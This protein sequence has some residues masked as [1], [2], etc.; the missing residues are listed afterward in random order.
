MAALRP[1]GR[2]GAQ[3]GVVAKQ[4]VQPGKHRRQPAA[5]AAGIA[6]RCTRTTC[7]RAAI[8]RGTGITGSRPYVVVPGR[9]EAAFPRCCREALHGL[10]HHHVAGRGDRP[11]RDGRQGKQEECEEGS[12]GCMVSSDCRCP[13]LLPPGADPPPP[14]FSSVDSCGTIEGGKNASDES[15]RTGDAGSHGQNGSRRHPSRAR[16]HRDGATPAVSVSPPR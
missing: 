15:A 11:T 2:R 12:H 13:R 6:R 7:R 10:E 16:R 3:Q 5:S 9:L 1:L 14:S 4:R 8:D